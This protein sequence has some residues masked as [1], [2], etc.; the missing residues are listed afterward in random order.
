LSSAGRLTLIV[1]K[2]LPLNVSDPRSLQLLL[3]QRLALLDSSLLRHCSQREELLQRSAA[4]H[5][6]L[7]PWLNSVPRQ[8]HKPTDN[9]LW[10]RQGCSFL[11]SKLHPCHTIAIHDDDGVHDAPGGGP[12]GSHLKLDFV[13]GVAAQP[14]A[15]GNVGPRTSSACHVELWGN[16]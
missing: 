11:V 13:P 16:L 8:A 9:K 5:E 6:R 14:L 1:E 3:E 7:R 10:V 4:E 12:N 15:H 2:N